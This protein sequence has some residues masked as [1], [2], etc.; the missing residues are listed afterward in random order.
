MVPPT[1]ASGNDRPT[2]WADC[3][4]RRGC[5]PPGAPTWPYTVRQLV[6]SSAPQVVRSSAPQLVSS[7]APQ[8]VSPPWHQ[9]NSSQSLRASPSLRR[10]S[11]LHSHSTASER[12]THRPSAK[13]PGQHTTLP[14]V[15]MA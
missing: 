6:S 14:H 7:S 2:A 15:E 12:C 8:P 13:A 9:G 4:M 1:T 3:D 10:T 11:M 5:S